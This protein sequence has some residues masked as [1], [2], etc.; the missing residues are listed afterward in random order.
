MCDTAQTN[1]AGAA[2][3]GRARERDRHRAREDAREC[4]R[5]RGR[6]GPGDQIVFDAIGEAALCMPSLV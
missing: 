4:A 5:D 6:P 3:V 1:G 2:R